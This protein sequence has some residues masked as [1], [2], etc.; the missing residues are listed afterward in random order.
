MLE[1]QPVDERFSTDIL[2][3][4]LTFETSY[5]LPGEG[6]PSRVRSDVVL[7]WPTWSQSAYRDWYLG[8]GFTD[9]PKIEIAVTL[10]V[11]QLAEE[12]DLRTFLAILP[13]DGPTIGVTSLVRTGPTVERRH[14]HDL[15]TSEVAVEVVYSGQYEL[16]EEMLEDGRRLDNDVTALGAWITTTLV[17]LGDLNLVYL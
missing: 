15:F 5:A 13:L 6:D 3:G 10:R 1:R 4:D 16:S 14:A 8:D 7:S 12:P 2:L 9:P 17:K 11:Q